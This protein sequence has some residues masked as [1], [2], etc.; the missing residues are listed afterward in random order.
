MAKLCFSCGKVLSENNYLE[1]QGQP[2]CNDCLSKIEDVSQTIQKEKDWYIE[3]EKSDSKQYYDKYQIVNEL[4][5][6]ILSGKFTKKS[7]VIINSKD[8]DKKW[9]KTESTLEEF[10]KNHFKLH[11]LYQPVWA[12]A[13]AG[14]KWGT[15]IGI[16]LKLTDTF[17]LLFSVD[18]GTAFLFLIAVAVVAIPRIGWMVTAAIAYAI[19][20]NTQM[21][22]FIIGLAS[23]LAG[24]ILGCFPGMAIGGIVGFIR[25]E[26]LPRAIDADPEPGVIILKAVIIPLI[27][28]ASLFYFYIFIFNPWLAKVLQ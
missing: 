11:L 9:Q 12:H 22:V 27:L 6:D 7:K 5:K 19:S 10:A 28:G 8:K 13:M 20:E 15:I 26:S 4:R 17:F 23:A 21:N 24:A 25:K 2:I 14:L 3:I 18:P 16:F 1:Y